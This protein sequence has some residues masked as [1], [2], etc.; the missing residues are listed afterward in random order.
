MFDKGPPQLWADATLYPGTRISSMDTG[1][2]E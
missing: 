1:S 2:I